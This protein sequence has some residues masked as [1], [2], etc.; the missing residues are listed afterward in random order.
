LGAAI[1][2]V[3]AMTRKILKKN[4][5]VM[6]I[7]SVRPLTQDE[8]QSPTG[9]KELEEF[10]IAVENKFGP[11]MSKDDFQDDPDY[12]DFV[13]PTY[14][15]YEDDEVYPSNMPDIDDIKEEHDVDTYDQYGGDHVRVPIGDD[16]RYG[17]VV[18]HKRELDGTV[19]R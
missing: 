2:S 3:P 17:N 13:T 6:Y 18:R 15:C 12:A 11:A 9:K 7:S 8:I 16:I 14:E 4:G 5:S 19:R 1:D 10:D